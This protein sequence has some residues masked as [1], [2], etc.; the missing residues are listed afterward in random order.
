MHLLNAHLV[1]LRMLR[2]MSVRPSASESNGIQGLYRVIYGFCRD[3]IGLKYTDS[4]K[5]KGSS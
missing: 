1:F 4:G 3:Y 5:E 2:P